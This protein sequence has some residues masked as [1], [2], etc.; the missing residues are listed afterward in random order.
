[1]ISLTVVTYCFPCRDSPPSPCSLRLTEKVCQCFLLG[2][3]CFSVWR[4][5]KMAAIANYTGRGWQRKSECA[6]IWIISALFFYLGLILHEQSSVP[7]EAFLWH[8]LKCWE[9]G[10]VADMLYS[11]VFKSHDASFSRDTDA[12]YQHGSLHQSPEDAACFLLAKSA[13][14]C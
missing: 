14:L 6:R 8:I 5:S 3:N 9:V 1:M 4:G 13:A 7:Q 10:K 11:L 12:T 2:V